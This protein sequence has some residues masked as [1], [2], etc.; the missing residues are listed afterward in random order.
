VQ[1]Q[2]D[3]ISTLKTVGSIRKAL[4]DLP[5]DLEQTYEKILTKVSPYYTDHVKKIL[6]CLAFGAPLKLHELHDAIIIDP[7]LDYL[8]EDARLSCPEDILDL[9][10]SLISITENGFVRLAHLSV[11]EYLLSPKIRNSRVAQ[12]ALDPKSS[13]LNICSSCLAYLSIK[14]LI[15][16]PA[17]SNIALQERK[18]QFPFLEHAAVEWPYYSRAAGE[19]PELD[20]AINKFFDVANHEQFMSW[21]QVLNSLP[22]PGVSSHRAWDSYPR[23]A[24]PLYYAS[25]FGLLRTVRFLINKGVPLDAPGSR[26]GGTALHGAILRGHLKIAKLLL[27]AGADASRADF[28][29]VT[30]LYTAISWDSHEAVSLL[31]EYGA[32]SHG[33]D[34]DDLSM[35]EIPTRVTEML[36]VER[37]QREKK[38][39]KG[40]LPGIERISEFVED[41]SGIAE[42]SV[43]VGDDDTVEKK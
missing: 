26:F 22:A 6:Q 36:K 29:G 27:E 38:E 19:P 30:P 1:C 32:S 17:T 42:F 33:T 9:C 18:F 31:M 34:I 10:N 24:T 8:D 35:V 15:S 21:V 11:R 3:Q 39:L 23:H 41:S 7:E 4:K 20:D 16:G 2:L 25:S 5:Q 12:F 28:H 37:V 13:M 14:D 43:E 40:T